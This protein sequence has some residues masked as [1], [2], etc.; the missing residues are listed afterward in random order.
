MLICCYCS[1]LEPYDTQPHGAK[2]LI[3]PRIGLLLSD[4]LVYVAVQFD[5]QARAVT[6]E[7][8]DE[9]LDKLLAPEMNAQPV[10][11]QLLP[12]HHFCGCHLPSQLF[13]TFKLLRG[14]FL[15]CHYLACWHRLILL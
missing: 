6:I 7:I 11:P 10:P 13:R 4:F 12:Q 1:I 5:R 2:D 3:P 14:D 15:A 8:N 9:A